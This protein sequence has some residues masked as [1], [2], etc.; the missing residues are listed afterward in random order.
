LY[1]KPDKDFHFDNNE[2]KNQGASKLP[3]QNKKAF[4]VLFYGKCEPL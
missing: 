4:T 2:G 3:E 1:K